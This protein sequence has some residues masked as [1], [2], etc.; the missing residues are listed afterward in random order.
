MNLSYMETSLK[1][2]IEHINI[3]YQQSDEQIFDQL[4]QSV[5]SEVR[6]HLTNFSKRIWT[7]QV[8]QVSNPRQEVVEI[9]D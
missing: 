2:F 4:A 6:A 8:V 9:L 1:Y 7:D 3:L 5:E